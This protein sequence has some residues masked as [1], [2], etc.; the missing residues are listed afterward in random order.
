MVG[1]ECRLTRCLFVVLFLCPCSPVKMVYSF[2]F[3]SIVYLSLRCLLRLH[4]T[5]PRLPQWG[6]SEN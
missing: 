1:N 6:I 2:L 4:T 5:F 3:L